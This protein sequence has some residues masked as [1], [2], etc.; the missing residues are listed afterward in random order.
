[1]SSKAT[2]RKKDVFKKQDDKDSRDMAM[3]LVTDLK[4]A[5]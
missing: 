2:K 3:D 5:N 4:K 1:M